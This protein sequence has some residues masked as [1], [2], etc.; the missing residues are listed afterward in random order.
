[1]HNWIFMPCFLWKAKKIECS[2]LF[3]STNL[4]CINLAALF[5]VVLLF[6]DIWLFIVVLFQSY[7]YAT[8]NKYLWLPPAGKD[9]RRGFS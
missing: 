4:T 5:S 9:L 1:M 3:L 6:E 7:I 8:I 2:A